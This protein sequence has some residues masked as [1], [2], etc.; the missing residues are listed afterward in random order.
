MKVIFYL[1]RWG[2]FHMGIVLMGIGSVMISEGADFH[3]MMLVVALSLAVLMGTAFYSF[4]SRRGTVSAM[5]VEEVYALLILSWIHIIMIV[6]FMAMLG[7][8]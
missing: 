6:F 3:S 1:L 4:M 8:F 5:S 7:M 2:F